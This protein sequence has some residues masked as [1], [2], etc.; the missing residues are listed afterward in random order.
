MQGEEEDEEEQG[1]EGDKEGGGEEAPPATTQPV[2]NARGGKFLPLC[3]KGD[4]ANQ[5]RSFRPAPTHVLEPW[6]GYV[7]YRTDAIYSRSLQKEGNCLLEAM[8]TAAGMGVGKLGVN[9]KALDDYMDAWRVDPVHGPSMGVLDRVLCQ[10]KS[11]FRLPVVKACSAN[12]KW[13][14]L[15]N[16]TEGIY[17]ALVLAEDDG[18]HVGHF[19]VYDAWR[20][21]LFM[22]PH[23]NKRDGVLRVQPKDKVNE[24]AARAYMF[25]HFQ[26]KTP[27]R[28]CKLVVAANRVS[29]TE[30]NT[31]DH[32]ADKQKRVAKKKQSMCD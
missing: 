5:V 8:T 3:V 19:I 31:K 15:L 6:R 21:L 18:K 30:F 16:M 24:A 27:L 10:A 1:E 32:Y 7:P 25:K 29:E 22:G 13:T 26:M 23:L 17:L 9:R 11:P 20:D 28:V 4:S 2:A 12:Q 14:L